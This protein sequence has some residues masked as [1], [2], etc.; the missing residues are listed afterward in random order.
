MCRDKYIAKKFIFILHENRLFTTLPNS[1]A[2][3]TDE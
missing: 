1:N 2:S 3:Q